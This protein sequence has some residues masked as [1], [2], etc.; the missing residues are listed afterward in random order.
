M[1]FSHKILR[2][3]LVT[4][5]TSFS[6]AQVSR[7]LHLIIIFNKFRNLILLQNDIIE[8]VEVENQDYFNYSV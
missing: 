4:I 1:Y 3:E 6:L 5:V 7:K 8:T 2:V